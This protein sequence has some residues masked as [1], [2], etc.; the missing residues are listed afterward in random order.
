MKSIFK[1]ENGNFSISRWILGAKF[2]RYLAIGAIAQVVLAGLDIIFL[3][4]ISPFMLSLGEESPSDTF[5]VLGIVNLDSKQIFFAIIFTVFIKNICGLTLQHKILMASAKREAEV[6]TALVKASMFQRV[7]VMKANH[8]SELLQTFTMVVGTL[9][10]SLFRPL[11]AFAGD[12]STMIAVILGLLIINSQVALLAI[13]YFAIFGLIIIRQVGKRQQRIGS[14][15]LD[16]HRQTLRTFTEIRLMSREL[17]LAHKENEAL[18]AMNAQRL[19]YSRLQA[20]ST[21]INAMPRYILELLLVFGIGALVPFL[22]HFQSSKPVL[23]TLALLIAAGYRILPS[24]NLVII[25]IGNFRNSIPMLNRIHG[26]A[27][28]FGIWDSPLVFDNSKSLKKRVDFRGNLVFDQVTYGYFNV[29]KEVFKEFNFSLAEKQTMLIIG[30]SGSGKTTLIGLAAGT[31][32][33][34]VGEI[35]ISFDGQSHPMD[36]SI[37]GISYLSQDVPLLD[38]SFAY[39]IALSDPSD[40]NFERLH[41]AARNAGILERI[42]NSPLGFETQIGEN[43]SMISAGERQR[44]G[45]AR[46]LYSNPGLM[47]LDEPTANLDAASE[48]IIWETIARLKGK[49]SILLVS[50]KLVPDDVYDVIL[51][52]GMGLEQ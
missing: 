20:T 46:S 14:D 22:N 44:L 29:E 13:G 18:A 15:S 35:Y 9:F 50:H 6:G 39:N 21:F 1:S 49:L 4:L 38:E 7:D 43:G 30:P 19:V 37:A 51:S 27:E 3:A 24:L 10:S 34:Q 26:L 36:S 52:L 25:A 40:F 47:I 11:I 5:E 23:P 42:A 33:P 48:S 32:M 16:M 45:I 28:R 2:S 31:L 8:S 17:R 41:E 12:I